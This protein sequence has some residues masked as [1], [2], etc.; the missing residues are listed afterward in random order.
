VLEP[1]KSPKDVEIE[2]QKEVVNARVQEYRQA[3]LAAKS[4]Y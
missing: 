4:V 2:K 3:A 1:Q